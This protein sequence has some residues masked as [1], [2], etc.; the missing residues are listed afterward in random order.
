MCAALAESDLQI[1][2]IVVTAQKREQSIQDVPVSVTAISADTIDSLG[3]QTTSDIARLSSS[4]TVIESNNKTNSALSIRGIG[5]NLFGIGI[6]QGVAVVVDDVAKV[7]QGQGLANMVD[8]ERIE[9]LRGPQSTLFGKASSAGVIN[10]TTK[11]PTDEFEGSIE[12]TATEENYHKVLAS[13][14]GPI[15]D[16]AGYRLT[17]HTS[18]L[19]GWVENLAAG[20]EDFNSEESQGF[21]AKLYWQINEDVDVLLKAYTVDEESQCCARV[22]GGFAPGAAL[23]GAIPQSVFAAGVTADSENTT[24]RYDTLPN[25][26][27]DSQGISARIT[28]DIGDFQLVSI[29]AYD[30]WDY[31][32]SEDVDLSELDVLG[33]FTGGAVSGNFYSDS[34]REL[35]FF[36]QELRLLSPTYDTYDY[37]LG[38]YY[39]D[40]D[41]DRSFFRILPVAPA[42]FVANA[43]NENYAVSANLTGAQASRRRSALGYAMPARKSAQRSQTSLLQLQP[44]S[45]PTMTMTRSLA[46]YQSS[47][48]WLTTRWSL[49]AIPVAIK[50][51]HTT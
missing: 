27:N 16:S 38:F 35:E 9:V 7:Q 19:D 11:G 5:T 18:E 41:V 30:E 39:S 48:F 49:P 47:V 24:V 40:S 33:I 42:N 34:V 46:K 26:D 10:I 4:L 8:V 22:L 32:N 44:P 50:H 37:L 12:V 29:T 1:E 36:S 14:S 23:F 31:T 17:A 25:S 6:E 21:S 2:E 20:A 13:V 28:A 45:S 3:L 15:G 43:G 51:R